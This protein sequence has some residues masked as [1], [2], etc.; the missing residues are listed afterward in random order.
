MTRAF[1]KFF[2]TAGPGKNDINYMVDPL[3]RINYDGLISLVEKQRYFVLHAP[4]QTGKTTSLLAMTKKIN[5]EEKFHCVYINVESAQ[6]ARN[7]TSGAMRTIVGILARQTE[8]FT[9]DSSLLR[10]MNEYLAQFGTDAFNT[11]LSALSKTL[12][13]PLVLLMDEIDSLIGDTLVSVLRQLRSGYESR[14]E[15]FPISVILCGVRDVRDYRIHRSDGDIITGGSCFNIKAES[16]R[17]GDFSDAEIRELYEQHTEA[18]GQKFDEDI[19]PKVWKLT[20]GQP[21]LVNALAHQATAEIPEGRDRSCSITLEII[22][23]AAERIILSRATHLDQLADKLSEPRVRRIIAPMISGGAWT[24]GIEEK[25]VQDDVQYVLDLGLIRRDGPNGKT[26]VIS[27]DIYKEVIPRELTSV[28]Q[29]NLVSRAEQ[30]WYVAA[31]GHLDMPKLM[32]DFQRF[33]RENIESWIDGFDYKEAGFQLL[34][35]AFMQRIVNGGGIIEREYAL[36]RGRVDLLARWRYPKESPRG[37]QTEQRILLE[38]KTIRKSRSPETVLREA[39]EQISRYA[40]RSN[41]TESHLVICDERP[42][43]TWDEKIY[44]RAEHHSGRD[45]WVWG[46]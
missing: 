38:L 25:P 17:L 13:K 28:T 18:T 5:E 6:T 36:G 41:A 27:N 34:L 42:E 35:Q 32:R 22:E 10:E 29:D 11:A 20:H 31:D 8:R 1:E 44:E 12:D 46:L 33:F 43:P 15:Y 26:L 45:I 16:L 19:Y 24:E 3:R 7:D 9:G 4:R 14:P 23:E 30:P 37:E 39:L 21:W 2:N 40:D